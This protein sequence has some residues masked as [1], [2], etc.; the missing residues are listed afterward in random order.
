MRQQPDFHS[1]KRGRLRKIQQAA[2]SF[3]LKL[4]QINTSEMRL[5]SRNSLRG[6]FSRENFEGEVIWP[7]GWVE[8]FG[9]E[10]S[11]NQLKWP[12]L[13][14]YSRLYTLQSVGAIKTFR[15]YGGFYIKDFILPRE[16]LA[17]RL[18]RSIFY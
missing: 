5:S 14:L 3:I 6:G 9:A 1:D 12:Y 15:N 18:R 4:W 17:V 7:P 11:F 13:Y 2:S 10:S 8:A 16:R